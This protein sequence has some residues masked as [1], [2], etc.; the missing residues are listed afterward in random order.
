MRSHVQRSHYRTFIAP[1]QGIFSC[2]GREVMPISLSIL[3]HPLILMIY[4]KVL[5]LWLLWRRMWTL[6]T[7]FLSYT[8]ISFVQNHNTTKYGNK[9]IV[10]LIERDSSFP[11]FYIWI[12]VCT[13]LKSLV[14]YKDNINLLMSN[15]VTVFIV[16]IL[17]F[18]LLY[19]KQSK[20]GTLHR[21]C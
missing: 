8:L 17:I 11:G 1:I 13:H 14:P 19:N 16:I 4:E 12:H 20:D 9:L 2:F 6:E 10:E 18:I 5:D 15:K 3:C 21:T 7:I